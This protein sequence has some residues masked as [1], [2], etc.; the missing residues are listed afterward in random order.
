MEIYRTQRYWISQNIPKG[1]KEIVGRCQF[2][3]IQSINFE[4]NNFTSPI[5]TI[6]ELIFFSVVSLMTELSIFF[7]KA[8]I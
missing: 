7:I 1:D 8:S 5:R 4:N 3:P 6:E 2:C